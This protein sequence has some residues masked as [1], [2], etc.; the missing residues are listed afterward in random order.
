MNVSHLIHITGL[1]A[2]ALTVFGLVGSNDRALRTI[3]APAERVNSTQAQSKSTPTCLVGHFLS[4]RAPMTIPRVP[5]ALEF[6]LRRRPCSLPPRGAMA[7]PCHL[8]KTF[9][10]SDCLR[11]N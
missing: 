4:L 5:A 10:L 8:V 1:I 9:V 11:A 3:G 7:T 2:L 6:Q